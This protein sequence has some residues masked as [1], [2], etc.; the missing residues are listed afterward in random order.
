MEF[1]ELPFLASWH[2]AYAIKSIPSPTPSS[3]A[4]GAASVACG[5]EETGCAFSGPES[6][7]TESSFI[8]AAMGLNVV[9]SSTLIIA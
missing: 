4:G 6:V 8:T 3:F 5:G 7:T 9:L 2:A 1:S